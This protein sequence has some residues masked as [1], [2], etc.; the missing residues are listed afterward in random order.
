MTVA[1]ALRALSPMPVWRIT[2][3]TG[4]PGGVRFNPGFLADMLGAAGAGA[5]D[6]RLGTLAV[7]SEVARVVAGGVDLLVMAMVLAVTAGGAS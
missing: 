3:L 2:G 4:D 6:V 1:K 5:V 7:G